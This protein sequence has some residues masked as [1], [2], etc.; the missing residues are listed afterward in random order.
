M[1]RMLSSMT[2]IDTGVASA[3]T[4]VYTGDTTLNDMVYHDQIDID[5]DI[6]ISTPGYLVA[7]ITRHDVSNPTLG[8]AASYGTET[9]SDTGYAV[10]AG[11][12]IAML[13]ALFHGD[14]IRIK[15][16][17]KNKSL[18]TSQYLETLL[19]R[20]DVSIEPLDS[21]NNPSLAALYA[22]NNVFRK[23]D[24][25]VQAKLMVEYSTPYTAVPDLM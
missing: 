25:S 3:S 15:E 10:G 6:G 18:T 19:F 20:G 9:G 5:Q 4:S 1:E 16:I 21:T 22:D 11:D 2:K 7:T 24:I 14:Q 13:N 23:N 8:Y 12:R 17:L